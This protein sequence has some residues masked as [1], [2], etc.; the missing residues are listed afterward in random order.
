MDDLSAACQTVEGLRCF[1]YNAD[2][3]QVPAAV[4]GWPTT[5]DFD[6][7]MGRGSDRLVFPIRVAV[8]R[9]DA[10]TSRDRLAEYVAG[11]GDTLSIKKAIESYAATSYDTAR[12]QSV[13]FGSVTVAGV[14][15]YLGATFNVEVYGPGE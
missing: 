2:S 12:V 9:A 5:Y 8:G 10:R 4:V 7:T 15:G 6:A 11:G 14:S 1:P 3:I 13:Q